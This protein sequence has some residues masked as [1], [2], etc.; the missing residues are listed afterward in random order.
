MNNSIELE[1]YKCGARAGFAGTRSNEVAYQ[2]GWRLKMPSRGKT[3]GQMCP[4]CAEKYERART[5]RKAKG[6]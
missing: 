5:A 4:T 3:F 1:C 2:F 6:Q